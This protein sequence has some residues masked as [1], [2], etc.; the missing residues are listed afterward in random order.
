MSHMYLKLLIA[1]LKLNIVVLIY[2]KSRKHDLKLVD[3]PKV[4][5]KQLSSSKVKT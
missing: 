3:L 4:K 1:G 5:I 2:N